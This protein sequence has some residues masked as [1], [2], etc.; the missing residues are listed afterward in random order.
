M[1]SSYFTPETIG[2]KSQQMLR[3]LENFRKRQN[4]IF[5]PEKSALLILDMQKYFLDNR[6]HAYIPNALSIVPKIATLAD[7]YYKMNLP[8]I[9][10]RH[11]NSPTDAKLMAEWWNELLSEKDDMS[12]IIPEL[13]LPYSIVIKKTQYDGFYQT[14]LEEI[15]KEKDIRQLVITGVM[16][17]LCCETTA[18]SAFV[19]GFSVFFPIDGTATYNENFHWA[20]LLNLSHGFAVPVLVEELQNNL[21]ASQ[22]V[23]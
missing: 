23:H 15:L 21:K 11:I 16:S 12:E 3:K 2:S 8:V 20:T 22:S 17:H 13:D 7:A 6:S 1:K 19:R 5:T 10:T 9:C 14:P 18:R 4:T